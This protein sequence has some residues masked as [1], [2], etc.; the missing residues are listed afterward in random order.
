MEKSQIQKVLIPGLAIASIIVLIGLLIGLK[1]E[2]TVAPKSKGGPVPPTPIK[3]SQTSDFNADG[4]T[5]KVPPIDAPEW[6]PFGENGLK[7]WDVVEGNGDVAPA[8]STVT[9]HYTG[10]LPTGGIFDSTVQRGDPPA[11]FPLGNL[12]KAWQIGIPGMKPGGVRRLLVPPELGYGER[13]S[14]PK[15]PGGA[16][17][18]FEVKLIEFN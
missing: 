9:I 15:I 7:I 13:G 10:W 8:G 14:P 6:K 3:P 17:L 11:N 18:V 16:T 2:S 5:L 12:I 1:S 4:T